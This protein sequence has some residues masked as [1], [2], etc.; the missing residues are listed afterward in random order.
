M[1]QPY[2]CV[3]KRGELWETRGVSSC[4]LG[5]RLPGSAQG[6]QDGI[7]AAW[8]WDG[9][10]LHVDNDRYGFYPLYYFHSSDGIGVSPSLVRLLA[11]G[12]PA[13]LD[14]TALGVFL[15]LGFFLGEDTPFKAIRALPPAAKFQWT[16]GQL[17]LSGEMAHLPPQS[18]SRSAAIDAF[19]FLFRQAMQRRHLP[20]V[21]IVLPLSGGRDSRHILFELCVSG[22]APVSCFTLRHFPPRADEDARVAVELARTLALPHQILD[23]PQSRLQAEFRKNVQTNFCADEHAQ[24]LPLT[25]ALL[26]QPQVIYDGIGG[27][28]LSAGLML[29]EQEIDFAAAGHFSE[30]AEAILDT[31]CNPLPSEAD[32]SRLLPRSLYQRFSRE[33]AHA[34]VLEELNRHRDTPNP[35]NQFYFW[36]RTRRE[37]ALGPY[38][39]PG[40][41]TTVFSPYLDH[42]LYDFLASLPAEA[43]LDCNLH[44]ET[45]AR[46]YPKYARIAYEKPYAQDWQSQRSRRFFRHWT[47]ETL[48]VLQ[49]SMP[50]LVHRSALFPRLTV[51]LLRGSGSIINVGPLILYLLQLESVSTPAD[52]L[53]ALEHG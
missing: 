8:H 42:D 26:G 15:R 19:I 12:A 24:L 35:G 14:D 30:W 16:K 53:A 3:R 28:M 45:I 29:D 49:K 2:F 34:R 31:H 39:M 32:L 18:M 36:N 43:I 9:Q 41:E 6:S 7:Y 25:D 23:Q 22:R 48:G 4:T 46:A 21:P 37:I 20:D 33:R 13:D 50:S 44:T 11:E 51:S 38:S 27:D 52:A 1:N 10:T 17:S 47:R 40:Q 5:H